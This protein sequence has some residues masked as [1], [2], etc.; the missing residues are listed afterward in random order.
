[1]Y[2]ENKYQYFYR[3]NEK[4]RQKKPTPEPSFLEKGKELVGLYKTDAEDFGWDSRPRL[5]PNPRREALYAEAANMGL[6]FYTTEQEADEIAIE[7]MASLK[8]NLRAAID[9]QL[10]RL[11]NPYKNWR[12]DHEKCTTLQ[13]NKWMENGKRVAIAMEGLDDPHHN[14]CYRAWNMEQEITAHGFH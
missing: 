9:F 1:M 11:K 10:K 12:Y 8:V 7:I 14:P 13:R 5:K 2:L 3:E 6:G 4:S